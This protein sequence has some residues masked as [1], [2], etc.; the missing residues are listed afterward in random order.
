MLRLLKRLYKIFTRRE[1]ILAAIVVLL[2][3]TT[4]LMEVAGL[5]LIF[6]YVKLIMD[7]SQIAILP[8]VDV[9]RASFG[10]DTDRKFL[11][12]L[13][14]FLLV[15]MLS[16]SALGVMNIWASSRFSLGRLASF[17]EDLYAIY[18]YRDYLSFLKVN[19]SVL[20]QN[21]LDETYQTIFNV[22]IPVFIILSELITLSAII[23]MLFILYPLQTFVMSL[24]VALMFGSFLLFTRKF[25][26]HIGNVRSRSNTARHQLVNDAFSTIKEMIVWNARGV[27]TGR[28]SKAVREFSYASSWNT[29]LYQMP[30]MLIEV[31]GFIVIIGMMV[32]YLQTA[33][34][35]SDVVSV[36]ALYGAAG[37]RMMPSFSRIT[38]NITQV[39]FSKRAFYSISED[40]LLRRAKKK[41][42][43]QGVAEESPLPFNR[44]IEIANV[45]FR[46]DPDAEKVLKDIS[47]IIH[48]HS[49]VAFVGSSGAGK[50]TLM[51]MLLGV[52]MPDSGEIRIDDTPLSEENIRNWRAH[53]G[54]VPQRVTLLDD[55]VASNIAFGVLPEKVDMEQVRWAAKVAQ[56]DQFIETELPQQY[57]TRLGERGIRLSGG[58][59]QR[60][61]IARA[62]YRRPSVLVMDEATAALDNITEREI[63][64]TLNELAGKITIIM[65]AHR[66]STVK[67]CDMIY[68]F[69]KGHISDWGTYNALLERNETFQKM[70]N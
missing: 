32:Y 40:L 68:L 69:E 17:S 50:S 45:S 6:V 2:F 51:D 54:Y 65:I 16:K 23:L 15:I 63:T 11:T 53:I 56:I 49:S 18:L 36:I 30:R 44:K 37:M 22:M 29:V 7:P 26:D 21:I 34:N 59:A 8:Y 28:F 1:K 5:G 60:I 24:T 55:T 35:P 9:I 62:L 27:F 25:L 39:R 12:V 43:P 58:Q 13:G 57:E 70:A 66:L 38:V 42:M 46:Y 19:P 64:E 14:L 41:L 3:S 33:E 61:A 10:L 52:F 48:K 47:L 4:S 67:H 20:K 31:T